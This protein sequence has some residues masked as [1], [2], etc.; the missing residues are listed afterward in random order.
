MQ[1]PELLIDSIVQQTM[2]FIAQLATHGGIRA[3]LAHV[4]NQV[5]VDLTEELERQG[6][7]KKVI[8]DMFGMAL[9][10]YH[11]RCQELRCSNTDGGKTLWEAVYGFLREKERTRGHE[12]YQRFRYDDPEIV[13]GV[14]SDLVS[15]GLVYR[16]GRGEDA[17]LLVAEAADFSSDNRVRNQANAYLVWLF[18]YRNGPISAERISELVHLPMTA[19]QSALDELLAEGHVSRSS[20]GDAVQYE[21]DVLSVP[22][23]TTQGWEAAVLDHFQAMISA[24]TRKLVS[25]SSGSRKTDEVGGS[26]WSLDVWR[27]H[28]FEA[29][30]K[31]TLRRLRA[32]VEDLRARIDA[33]NATSGE[34]EAR[35]K[36]VVYLGQYVASEHDPAAINEADTETRPGNETH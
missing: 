24:I 7:R 3:P 20:G 34:A 18:V 28:P 30:A 23:G 19:C 26:T 27:G 32:E 9:R 21:S 5:F 36:I 10:T 25:N 14:L 33:H 17:S 1:S 22:P 16:A 6:V 12:V 8:A 11:R 13:T 2:V 15:T 4:A 29:E 31:G 35:E